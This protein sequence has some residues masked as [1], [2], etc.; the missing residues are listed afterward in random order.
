VRTKNT[1]E[2]FVK[3]CCRLSPRKA[4]TLQNVQKKGGSTSSNNTNQGHNSNAKTRSSTA[5]GID[6]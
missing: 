1:K 3:N 6:T 5:K 2:N 4:Q